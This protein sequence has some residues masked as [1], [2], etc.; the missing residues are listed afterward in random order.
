MAGIDAMV[1]RNLTLIALVSGAFLGKSQL[2]SFRCKVSRARASLGPTRTRFGPASM[3]TT[4]RGSLFSLTPPP[5]P[6]PLRWP[7]V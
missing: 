1:E 5:M 7:I 3:A 6:R 2:H 4:Y